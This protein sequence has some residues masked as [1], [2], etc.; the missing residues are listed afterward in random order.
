MTESL[1]VNLHINGIDRPKPKVE[2]PP[3]LKHAYLAPKEKI[4]KEVQTEL[5]LAII[6]EELIPAKNRFSTL[7]ELSEHYGFNKKLKLDKLISHPDQ[8]EFLEHY[9]ESNPKSCLLDAV[10]GFGKSFVSIVASLSVEDGKTVILVKSLLLAEQFKNELEEFFNY[11]EEECAVLCGSNSKE[12]EKRENRKKI[13]NSKKVKVIIATYQTAQFDLVGR[14]HK[15]EDKC[16]EPITN[17]KEAN[18]ELT[19]LDECHSGLGKNAGAIVHRETQANNLKT[20]AM[21]GSLFSHSNTLAQKRLKIL[22]SLQI[23]ENEVFTTG[24]PDIESKIKYIP[25]NLTKK[26][27][28][29]LY[30]LKNIIS[31]LTNSL[32]R[33]LE[34][35]SDKDKSFY[36]IIEKTSKTFKMNEHLQA[37]ALPSREQIELIKNDLKLLTD[38]TSKKHKNTASFCNCRLD[39]IQTVISY[40]QQL[41]HSSHFTLIARITSDIHKHFIIP[42]KRKEK[43]KSYKQESS[44]NKTK[45]NLI[46]AQKPTDEIFSSLH[47][48]GFRDTLKAIMHTP[49]AHLNYSIED[50]YNM[51]TKELEKFNTLEENDSKIAEL[52]KLNSKI[53]DMENNKILT[54]TDNRSTARFLAWALRKNKTNCN[55]IVGLKNKSEA[56]LL[57][58]KES[59]LKFAANI[60]HHLTAT[61]SIAGEGIGFKKLTD[62]ICFNVPKSGIQLLQ[63]AGR[64]GRLAG[65]RFAGR[66]YC[67]GTKTNRFNEENNFKRAIREYEEIQSSRILAINSRR[68]KQ[69]QN[70]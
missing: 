38:D 8:I 41:L 29:N 5:E 30:R 69:E 56:T 65:T 27:S 10:T 44:Y 61:T 13:W 21:T 22:R 58:Q 20:I 70:D 55:A 67:L 25:V 23:K 31:N 49:K 68:R 26:T 12:K 14:E 2:I 52:F 1:L 48:E 35:V 50:L 4:E 24:A 54:L 37:E 6:K 62:A 42:E 17:C 46:L 47:L 45:L 33:E 16:I 60:L 3:S 64:T 18:I 63:I 40:Y 9:L 57:E 66:I 28:S 15:D 53:L 32:L 39:A 11:K 7:A 59:L 34:E 36:R 19:I 43:N 51:L